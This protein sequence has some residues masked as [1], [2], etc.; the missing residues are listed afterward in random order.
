MGTNLTENE[1]IKECKELWLGKNGIEESGLSKDDY[2]EKTES[3]NILKEKGYPYRC[4]LC[5]YTFGSM[6]N[7]PYPWDI[8]IKNCSECPFVKQYGKVCI[9]LGFKE[10]EIPTKEWLDIIRNLKEETN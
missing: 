5:K 10:I 2:I 7:A 3:G 4:P 6:E 8:D 9:D 1:A